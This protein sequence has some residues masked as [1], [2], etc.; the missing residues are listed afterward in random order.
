MSKIVKFISDKIHNL[1]SFIQKE[2]MLLCALYGGILLYPIIFLPLNTIYVFMVERFHKSTLLIGHDCM[3][4]F[5]FSYK[6][7]RFIHVHT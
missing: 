5:F 7:F 3:K 1:Y 2:K 4:L 6:I